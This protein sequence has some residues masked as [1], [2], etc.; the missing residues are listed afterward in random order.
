MCHQKQVIFD[1]LNVFESVLPTF[2]SL[3]RITLLA[4]M[5]PI[6][7]MVNSINRTT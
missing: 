2:S 4:L 3:L 1:V 7:G 5:Q 6:S